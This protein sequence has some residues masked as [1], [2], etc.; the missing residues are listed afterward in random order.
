MLVLD[1]AVPP[2]LWAAASALVHASLGM[3]GAIIEGGF[4][5]M[6]ISDAFFCFF[7]KPLILSGARLKK[8]K[9]MCSSW[10]TFRSLM[11]FALF[12]FQFWKCR[13]IVILLAFRIIDEDRPRRWLVSEGNDPENAPRAP[14]EIEDVTRMERN[15]EDLIC[16]A[17]DGI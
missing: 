17:R 7:S 1:Q 4:D 15:G 8:N 6:G 3:P 14:K 10:S 12:T 13:W 16:H 11:K 2:A 5:C 9:K